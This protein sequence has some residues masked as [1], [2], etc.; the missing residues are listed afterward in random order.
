MS[1]TK[2]SKAEK[3]AFW[4]GFG[5]FPLVCGLIYV[6]SII[7]GEAASIV[8]FHLAAAIAE[9]VVIPAPVS[10]TYYVLPPANTQGN[11]GPI[12]QDGNLR[13]GVTNGAR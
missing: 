5:A 11:W 8:E 9:R 10:Q 12:E 3:E 1:K 13:V 7:V 2:S 4:V 6:A